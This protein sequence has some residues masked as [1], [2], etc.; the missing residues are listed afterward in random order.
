M[1]K[2]KASVK[3]ELD[4][5]DDGLPHVE[6]ARVARRGAPGSRAR[7]T[8]VKDEVAVPRG[9]DEWKRLRV[10]A[11]VDNPAQ[12][13]ESNRRIAIKQLVEWQNWQDDWFNHFL[14]TMS[15][16]LSRVIQ[17]KLSGIRFKYTDEKASAYELYE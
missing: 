11:G 16:E 9:K 5:G 6:G 7:A 15:E 2:R 12:D 3:R 17:A 13:L 1:T 4:L 8:R 14:W 10:R